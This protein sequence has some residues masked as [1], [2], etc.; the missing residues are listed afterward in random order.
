MDRRQLILLAMEALGVLPQHMQKIQRMPYP[1]AVRGLEALKAEARKRYKRAAFE[2]HPD[3]NQD[4]PDA[5][6]KFKA[7][8][9]VL[10]DLEKLRVQ[11]PAPRPVVQFVHIP[12][13]TPYGSAVTYTTS[14]TTTTT[15][16]DATQA[17]FIRIN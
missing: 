11:P 10:A 2:W 15:T 17:V 1:Q 3:R 4:D 8:G 7:L 9:A 14:S 5:E 12:R 13:T 16:Y 6:A